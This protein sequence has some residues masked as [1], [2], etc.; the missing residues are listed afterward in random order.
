[1]CSSNFPEWDPADPHVQADQIHAY[2]RL[3][4]ACPIAHSNTLHWTI[5]RHADAVRILED[6]ETFSNA[7]STHCSV[8]NGMDPPEHTAYRAIVE[9]YFTPESM[10]SFAPVLRTITRELIEQCEGTIDVISS[11]AQPFSVRAQCAFMGWPSTLHQPLLDWVA[12]NHLATRSA[13]KAKQTQVAQQFD[14]YIRH[15]LDL[16]RELA[17][18]APNDVTSQLLAERIDG[19]ELDDAALVSLIRNWTVGELGTIAACV[20]IICQFLAQRP[21]IQ[22]LLRERPNL[23][24]AAIDEILRIEA[25]LIANRRRVTKETSIAGHTLQTGDRLTVVWASANRDESVFGPEPDRFDLNRNPDDN[26]LYGK[27]IHVCPGAP[28]ARLELR[29]VVD[30][31]LARF[32]LAPDPLVQ[33]RKAIYPSGG[34]ASLSVRLLARV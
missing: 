17:E 15:Q 27:G 3:R 28:L 31:L 8:P 5:L 4:N 20:G 9:R 30:E 6:H 2:D 16:R 23:R 25:P 29:V 24:D 14:S 7:V 12:A 34:Y 11:L 21:D 33:P 1:M 22:A 19:R 13:D 32:E 10:R 18:A 26:L